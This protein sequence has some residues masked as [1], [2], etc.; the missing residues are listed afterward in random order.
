M[1][2][3]S[4]AFAKK[5][6]LMSFIS[7]SLCG[8]LIVFCKALSIHAS[9]WIKL[10][11][12]FLPILLSSGFLL[13]LGV[14]LIR[15]HMHERKGL[16][17]DFRRLLTGSLDVALSTSYLSLP[18][19][20]VYLVLWILLGV[21]FLLREIPFLGPFF[22]AIFASGPF[23]LI[24]CSLLLC[25]LNIS[26]LFFLAPAAAHQSIKRVILP[27]NSIALSKQSH[28]LASFSLSRRCCQRS[29]WGVCSLLQQF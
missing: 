7:L 5:K 6:L 11:L 20:L 26:L 19:V 18:P 22:N 14:L 21:F 1:S 25:L 9:S 28:L 10:S 8:I 23:L 17:L 13:G 29:S 27:I 24:F 3:W 15:M 16:A 4:H 12:L 2:A